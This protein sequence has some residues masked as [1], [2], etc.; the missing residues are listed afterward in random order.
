MTSQL[1]RVQEKVKPNKD[2]MFLSHTVNP[3]QDSAEALA[4]Y[5]KTHKADLTRWNFVT[6]EKEK[7]YTQARQ[8]F[9]LPVEA[10]NGGADDFIHSNMLVLVDKEK[11]IRGY[12]DGTSITE[13]NKLIDD[14][15]MLLADYERRNPTLNNKITKKTKDE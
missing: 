1:Y 9:F 12:Y 13:V 6:G 15:K 8:G 7:I 4:A 14:I 5:A 11:R 3:S 10:G 2:V